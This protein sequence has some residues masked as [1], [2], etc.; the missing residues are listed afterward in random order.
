MVAALIEAGADVNHKNRSGDEVIAALYLA[1][2]N[3]RYEDRRP[4]C[5]KIVRLLLRAGASLDGV[6]GTDSAEEAFSE[7]E[8]MTRRFNSD[9]FRLEGSATFPEFLAVRD[10]LA[11]VRKA[12]SYA[13]FVQLP[14]C[15]DVLVLRTLAL[16]GRARPTDGVGAFLVTSPNEITWKVLS[17][18]R[19]GLDL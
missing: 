18:W 7:M 15:K 2:T 5:L 4:H 8:N 14:L 12:G 1:I 11:G 10:T 9:D 13:R 6:Y 16:R 17:Y 19:G 3:S